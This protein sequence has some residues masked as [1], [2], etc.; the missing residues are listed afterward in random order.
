MIQLHLSQR[1]IR[2]IILSLSCSTSSLPL[3]AEYSTWDWWTFRNIRRTLS[4]TD[5]FQSVHIPFWPLSG[6]THRTDMVSVRLSFLHIPLYSD[7]LQQKQR[8]ANTTFAIPIVKALFAHRAGITHPIPTGIILHRFGYVLL[9]E[10]TPT[11]HAHIFGHSFALPLIWT[12]VLCL[13]CPF[14]PHFD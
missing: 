4:S 6:L 11:V 1:R 14:R 10:H 5:R 9:L 13:F 3:Q 8:V 2:S 12:S 7:C